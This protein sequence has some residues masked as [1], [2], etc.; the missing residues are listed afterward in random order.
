MT[1][2]TDGIFSQQPDLKRL[3]RALQR[4]KGFGLYFARC[5]TTALRNELVATLKKALT[6]PIIE[7][8]LSPDNDIYIDVQMAQLLE[9]ASDDAIVFIYDIE[10]I[11]VLENRHVIQELNWRRG[12]YGRMNHPVVFWL[13]EFLV[14]EI[15]NEAPDFSDWYSG[16]Y[17]FSLSQTEKLNLITRTWQMLNEHFVEQLS[18][19]EKERWIINLKN[20]LAEI[21][22]Q[23]KSKAKCDLLN[24]LGHLCNSLGMN[25]EALAYY[26][27]ALKIQ[28]EINDK[29]GEGATLNNISQVYNA[30]GNYDKSLYYLKQS[31]KISQ[32]IKDKNGESVTLINIS[33][34]HKVKGKIN[35]ALDYVNQALNIAKQT[36]NKRNEGAALN[37]LAMLNRIKGDNSLALFYLF[38]SL[39]IKRGMNDKQGES[40]VL[41]DLSQIYHDEGDYDNALIN[42]EQSLKIS[43]KIGDKQVESMVLNNISQVYSDKGDYDTALQ[44]LEQSL[45]I[46]QNISDK[47]GECVTLFNIGDIY[48]W[49]I[50]KP[51][52]AMSVWLD[53]YQIAKQI[54][55]AE[56]LT[57][58]DKLAKQ[59]GGEGLDYW[60]ALSQ[61]T[62][63]RSDV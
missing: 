34:I 58:L 54:G 59:L 24:R 12:F 30:K 43:R 19:K 2:A 37:H 18:L 50:N 61:T 60:E 32:D 3:I 13:P 49:Q 42:L 17:E 62:P 36:H 31:L 7:L 40:Q 5:N 16:I 14:N 8:T 56:A 22:E 26:E 38:K 55:H 25:N 4:C 39:E 53:A 41:N 46:Q 35:I 11:S 63:K 27:Q 51:Q 23:E 45:K 28:E 44:F 20:L 33:Q 21:G 48:Y 52:Q 29:Q 57:N 6:A 47:A 9:N 1:T 15:F 10:K